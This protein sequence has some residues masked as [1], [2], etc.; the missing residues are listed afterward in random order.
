MSRLDSLQQEVLDAFFEREQ[1]FF[2][3]GGAALAGFHLK[4]RETKDLDFFTT[5][6]CI[7]QGAAALELVARD[8]G[9]SLESLIAAPTFRRYLL[10]RG[11]SSVVVELVMDFAPQIA[12][13]KVLFGKVRIDPP[14][15]ITANKL[16]TLLSRAEIRDL[17]DLRA[18]EAAGYSV[19]DH[20]PL[21]AQKDGGLT[22]GQL[23]WVLS[24]IQIGDDAR[25]PGE[26]SA[27]Q[28]REYLADL[29]SR[30][31]KMAFPEAT[32]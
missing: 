16:C 15:E 1:R 3:T 17:V 27:A 23:A 29:E 12:P 4:H 20:L 31:T 21:A 10:R 13:S 28:L 9:G 32:V 26:V 6:D 2:L 7:E 24:Q 25:I 18:L 11:S 14:A 30:L 22:P 5:E 8:L 19:E